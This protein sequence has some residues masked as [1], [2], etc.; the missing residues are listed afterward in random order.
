LSVAVT[1]GES[2]VYRAF[3][4]YP[5]GFLFRA[6]D[7]TGPGPAGALELDLNGD[8]QWDQRAPLVTLG[9]RSAFAD[10]TGDGV[11]SA[12][13]EPGLH[14]VGDSALELLLPFGGDANPATL[15]ATVSARISLLLSAGI[16]E[17]PTLGG[18]YVVNARV[19]TVDPDSDGPDDDRGLPPQVHEFELP[20][21]I[22]GPKLVPFAGL[23]VRDL[24]LHRRGRHADRVTVE[25]QFALGRRSN[26]VDLAS[27]S[28]A[29]VI[30]PFRQTIA[31][32]AL[33]ATG[34]GYRFK[35]RSPGIV[36]LLLRRDGRFSIDAR[37]LHWLDHPHRRISVS[38][39]IGDDIGSVSVNP[40]DKGHQG[41]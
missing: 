3:V 41:R 28:I 19:T 37:R 15:V 14:V 25:G 8:G 24:D 1:V 29:I 40:R 16:L 38:L 7:S 27:E 33:V 32:S 2:E 10:V 35:G 12:A 31:G 34:H 22:N 11:Y 6:F 26:G 9:P 20:L 5:P 36:S 39:R 18:R 4:A 13:I 23:V 21:V 17:S 30:G